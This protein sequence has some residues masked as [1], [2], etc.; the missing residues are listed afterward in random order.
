[1]R[2]EQLLLRRVVSCRVPWQV[3]VSIW[4]VSKLLFHH[5]SSLGWDMPTQIFFSRNLLTT[6]IAALVKVAVVVTFNGDILSSGSKWWPWAKIWTLPEENERN[7]DLWTTRARSWEWSEM[8]RPPSPFTALQL[9]GRRFWISWSTTSSAHKLPDETY[10][11][12]T[13]TWKYC[14]ERRVIRTNL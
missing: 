1:M 4:Q 9:E 5:T 6:E 8:W 14:N 11:Q 10:T 2:Y 12:K 13:H 3:F 7:R